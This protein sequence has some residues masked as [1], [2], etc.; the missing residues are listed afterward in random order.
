MNAKQRR[1]IYRRLRRL[2]CT[3]APVII[4]GLYYNDPPRIV[5]RVSTVIRTRGEVYCQ[6]DVPGRDRPRVVHAH[7]L[8]EVP[9][10][11]RFN[12]EGYRHAHS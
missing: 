5:A 3:S 12:Y 7:N 11:Q 10:H 8:R 6:V 9:K 4:N 2:K 1:T